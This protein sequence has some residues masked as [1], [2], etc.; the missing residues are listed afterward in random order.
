MRKNEVV[1]VFNLSNGYIHRYCTGPAIDASYARCTGRCSIESKK[2]GG[3]SHSHSS[4]H[5][6]I[7]MLSSIRLKS[8]SIRDVL[9]NSLKNKLNYV[10]GSHILLGKNFLNAMGNSLCMKI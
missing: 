8:S 6:M 3:N 7:G 5:N 4:L 9:V 1:I 10:I 2:L